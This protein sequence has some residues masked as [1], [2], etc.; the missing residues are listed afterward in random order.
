ML[1]VHLITSLESGGVQKVLLNYL[2]S[3][4]TV[5]C[6]NIVYSL[7]GEDFYSDRIRDLGVKVRHL[8]KPKYWG[9]FLIDSIFA[10]GC[11]KAWMYHA[12]IVSVI[13]KLNFRKKVFWSIHHGGLDR[14]TDSYST[15]I[16]T[17]LSSILSWVVTEKVVF[18]S[19]SCRIK[20]FNYGFRKSNSVVIYNNVEVLPEVFECTSRNGITFIGRDHPNQ[21]LVLFLKACRVV[22]TLCK[23]SVFNIVGKSTDLRLVNG[24]FG[25]R[26]KFYGELK[27]VGCIY[28][29][30]EIYI[31][32]SYT[33]SFGL[34]I[35]EAILAGCT[36]ICPDADIFREVTCNQA[37]YYEQDNLES[38][39][40]TIMAVRGLREPDSDLYHTMKNKYSKSQT[41]VI[42]AKL[43]RECEC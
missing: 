11:F 7:H 38:L 41:T 39:V 13:A 20:H 18:V 15:Y 42:L 28:H 37:N 9:Q 2:E 33:E 19:E 25:S 8:N 36:V 40:E 30:T 32:T 12:C 29:E 23:D 21:N 6:N 14:K 1:N 26:Y 35:I 10:N 4:D 17:Y 16:S 34:T 31:C 22:E 3:I 5:G 24:C 43:L 27:S